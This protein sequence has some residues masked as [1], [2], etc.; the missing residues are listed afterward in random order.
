M[1]KSSYERRPTGMK[2]LKY[3]MVG[4]GIGAYIGDTHRHGAEMDGLAEL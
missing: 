1:M 4:G 2:R 3:G